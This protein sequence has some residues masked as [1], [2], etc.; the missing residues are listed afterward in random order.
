MP[1]IRTQSSQSRTEQESRILLAIQTIKNREIASIQV[2]K[3]FNV[4]R[5]TLRDDLLDKIPRWLRKIPYMEDN[6][7]L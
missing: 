5:T 4:P 6:G 1:P 2:A 7:H 3:R